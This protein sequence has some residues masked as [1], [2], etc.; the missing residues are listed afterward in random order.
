MFGW[1]NNS[2]SSTTTARSATYP[3]RRAGSTSGG[4]ARAVEGSIRPPSSSSASSS[5]ST[6]NGGSNGE[7][8]T[9]AQHLQSFLDDPTLK[10]S[11]RRVSSG[12]SSP[13]SVA[14]AP[15]NFRDKVIRVS[16]RACV[17]PEKLRRKNKF[18]DV[19]FNPTLPNP[20]SLHPLFFSHEHCAKTIRRTIQS[21][22]RRMEIL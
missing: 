9:R 6:A 1:S 13:S 21:F 17:P 7:S 22:R 19:F 12:M 2:S 18:D 10:R 11:T 5:M 20:P 15:D 4:A 14:L 16:I 3:G 8:Y